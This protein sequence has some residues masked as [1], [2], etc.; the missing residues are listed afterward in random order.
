[1]MKVM[2]VELIMATYNKQIN[3]SEPLQQSIKETAFVLEAHTAARQTD[4]KTFIQLKPP[5][6]QWPPPSAPTLGL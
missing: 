5:T 4:I 1:M 2:L 6:F 3:P